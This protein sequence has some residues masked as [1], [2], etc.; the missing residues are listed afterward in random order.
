MIGK[1]FITFPKLSAINKKESDAQIEKR[2]TSLTETRILDISTPVQV[3]FC[4]SRRPTIST[5][6]PVFIL[7]LSILQIIALERS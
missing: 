3:V 4:V 1:K 5:S 2:I 7:P 6:S